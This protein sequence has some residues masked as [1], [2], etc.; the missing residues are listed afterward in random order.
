MQKLN[1][2]KAGT[3]IISI[4]CGI[5]NTNLSD[6]EI[7]VVGDNYDN[8][9]P[10]KSITGITSAT[11]TVLGTDN[12]RVAKILAKFIRN[13]IL[14]YL[15][16]SFED[17]LEIHVEVKKN[18]IYCSTFNVE[19]DNNYCVVYFR[20]HSHKVTGKDM[21]EIMICKEIEHHILVAL[22]PD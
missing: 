8:T 3:E 20:Q 14:N 16:K 22:I 1:F 19:I 9:I 17:H 18:F 11:I 4:Y 13:S 21:I 7:K 10:I 12:E 5:D 6:N 2:T 15:G